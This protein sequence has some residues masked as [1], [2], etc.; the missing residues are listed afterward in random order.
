MKKT[1]NFTLKLNSFAN[2]FVFVVRE[3]RG[4]SHAFGERKRLSDSHT[5]PRKGPD[6]GVVLLVTFKLFP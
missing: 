3:K 6:L 5:N 2:K 4:S 1:L